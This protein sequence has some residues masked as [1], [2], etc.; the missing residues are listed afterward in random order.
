MKKISLKAK[1][2]RLTENVPDP[3]LNCLRLC[4]V[5]Y[6]RITLEMP[7]KMLMCFLCLYLYL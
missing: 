5:I 4:E 2:G 6:I 7:T 1:E 3:K